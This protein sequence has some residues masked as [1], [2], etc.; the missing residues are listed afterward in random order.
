MIHAE[1]LSIIAAS[2]ASLRR[3]KTH[4]PSP[5]ATE[6][7]DKKPYSVLGVNVPWNRR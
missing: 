7:E 2:V 5:R 4:S 6:S 1:P 3:L